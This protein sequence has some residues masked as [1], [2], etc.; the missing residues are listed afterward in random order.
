MSAAAVAVEVVLQPFM[1]VFGRKRP[2][3]PTAEVR[4]WRSF[5]YVALLIQSGHPVHATSV[6]RWVDGCLPRRDRIVPPARLAIL[7][8]D[9]LTDERQSVRSAC[10]IAA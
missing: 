1:V 9:T 8:T 3:P 7:D 4:T 10:V 5:G 2:D 6:L